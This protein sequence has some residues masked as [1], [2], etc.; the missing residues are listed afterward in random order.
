MRVKISAVFT[1]TGPAET[2]SFMQTKEFHLD[3][4]PRDAAAFDFA[5]GA[6]YLPGSYLGDISMVRRSA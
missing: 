2:K 5:A 3:L 6:F 1:G 4:K